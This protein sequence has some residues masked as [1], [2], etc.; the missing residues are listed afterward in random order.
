M[1][2]TTFTQVCTVIVL[3]EK[4]VK[5][6]TEIY[7]NDDY[8]ELLVI[9]LQGFSL[10]WR[11]RLHKCE[12]K[13]VD[14]A[15]WSLIGCLRW[16]HLSLHQYWIQYLWFCCFYLFLFFMLQEFSAKSVEKLK[17]NKFKM[18]ANY[19]F[20]PFDVFIQYFHVSG[21]VRH[22][23]ATCMSIKGLIWCY[24]FYFSDINVTIYCFPAAAASHL[25]WLY[26]M[27]LLM[28]ESWPYVAAFL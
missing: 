2:V 20:E 12:N 24:G 15:V 10:F 9:S 1:S 18:F 25:K 28:Y 17:S 5:Y 11:E 23:H 8:G 19:S 6:C 16:C 4:R 14:G 3:F 21:G 27:F 22:S 13:S 7:L 26:K